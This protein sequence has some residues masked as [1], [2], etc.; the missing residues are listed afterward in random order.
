M[1]AHVFAGHP[2][3]HSLTI[4]TN[5]SLEFYLQLHAKSTLISTM[6]CRTATTTAAAN[7]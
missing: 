1:Y 2:L 5:K 3:T 6:L 7:R 4:N